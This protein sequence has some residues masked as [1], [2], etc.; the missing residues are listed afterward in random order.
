MNALFS[1]CSSFWN[2]L[3]IEEQRNLRTLRD[4]A[5]LKSVN[6]V[7]TRYLNAPALPIHDFKAFKDNIPMGNNED[8]HP[9]DTTDT[10]TNQEITIPFFVCCEQKN[11]P[12]LP[13]PLVL[14]KVELKEMKSTSE[15]SGFKV[16]SLDQLVF[17]S[18]CGYYEL[19]YNPN[20]HMLRAVLTRADCNKT[21]NQ[22]SNRASTNSQS[23]ES[24]NSN[25]GKCVLCWDAEANICFF[26]CG[27][28][29]G[30]IDC[31]RAHDRQ[32]QKKCPICRQHYKGF[33]RVYAV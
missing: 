32:P 30:C 26:P 31:I 21:R 17:L 23:A 22:T 20:Q 25:Q 1:Y 4:K 24:V 8:E 27:H 6:Y 3:Q 15:F 11:L 7:A 2:S 28:L 9:T 14:S 18:C 19:T 16:S 33:F 10:K 13:Y 29:I 12:R 5:I